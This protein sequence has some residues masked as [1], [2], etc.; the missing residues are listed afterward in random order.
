[1]TKYVGGGNPTRRAL[2][3]NSLDWAELEH[4]SAHIRD[5]ESRFRTERAMKRLSTTK[6]IEREIAETMAQRQ[7]LVSRLSDRLANQVAAPSATP[8]EARI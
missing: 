2:D 4:L 3:R 8:A 5:L 6:A 1:M 7:R